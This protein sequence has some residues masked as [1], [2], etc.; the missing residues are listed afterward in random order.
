MP[1]TDATQEKLQQSF[2]AQRR[3]DLLA[4]RTKNNSRALDTQTSQ[5]P[6]S[7]E[8]LK[9]AEELL[10]HNPVAKSAVIS[11]SKP[12]RTRRLESRVKNKKEKK[13]GSQVIEERTLDSALS[14][15][16][17]GPKRPS[18]AERK[19][20]LA[21]TIKPTLAK[22]KSKRK[23]RKVN[24]KQSAVPRKVNNLVVRNVKGDS[25]PKRKGSASTISKTPGFDSLRNALVGGSTKSRNNI[26]KTDATK[27]QI[28]RKIAVEIFAT[29]LIPFSHSR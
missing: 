21:K 5:A 6:T 25:S 11:D 15:T 28:L 3:K 19:A 13:G 7:K 10:E 9:V 1:S 12:R 8:K 22:K 29:K 17:A 24:A 2:V 4:T 16:S 14:S 27:L 23:V 20:E 26:E 18:E